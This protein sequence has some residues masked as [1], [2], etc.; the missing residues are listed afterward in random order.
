MGRKPLAAGGSGAIPRWISVAAV[1]A[2]LTVVA[3]CELPQGLREDYMFKDRIE[4]S[5][6]PRIVR[7]DP[8]GNAIVPTD[9]RRAR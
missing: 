6:A 8:Y 1:G 4:P 2:V 9:E 5:R 7:H 3:G